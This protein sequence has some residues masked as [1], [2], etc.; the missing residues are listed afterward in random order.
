MNLLGN[1]LI[2]VAL[3]AT[4]LSAIHYY[5]SAVSSTQSVKSARLW[6][7]VGAAAI[8]ALS[9]LLLS[10]LMQHDFSN[11]YVYSYSSRNLPMHFLISSFYAGQEGSFLFWV[12]CSAVIGL[13]LMHHTGKRKSEPW[14]MSVYMGVQTFLI[15][16][17]YAK[18]PF[19]SVWEKVPQ[20]PLG[21]LPAD[22]SGLNPLLQNVWMVIH[23]PV[24]F[25]GFA[26]MIIPFSFAILYI[27]FS[28]AGV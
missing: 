4:V 13:A 19:L 2:F 14:V 8:V 10:L 21:Q 15:L 23:P 9:G 1:G 3:T 26:S 7:R 17:L 11:G 24:L 5:R 6:L 22:G 27:S 25:L 28:S 20:L 16:L 12:L 18:T